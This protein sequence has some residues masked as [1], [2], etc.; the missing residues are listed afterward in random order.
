MKRGWNGG[1]WIKAALTTQ[2][3]KALLAAMLLVAS[4]VALQPLL[5][6]AQAAEPENLMQNVLTETLDDK[7]VT[8]TGELPPNAHLELAPV[9]DEAV[10]QVLEAADMPE[11]TSL[12]AVDVKIVEEDGTAWQPSQLDV[13]VK[14]ENLDVDNPAGVSVI[15]VLDDVDA[16]AQ[17][18]EEGASADSPADAPTEVQS[19]ELATAL[20]EAAD[21]AHE[22]TGANETIYLATLGD[23]EV[24][25]SSVAFEAD[26]FSVYIVAET[27]YLRTYRFFT[28]DEYGDYVEYAFYTDS[29][30]TTFTQT[31]KNGESPTVPQNPTNRQDSSLAFAGWYQGKV[32]GGSVV[33]EDEPYDFDNI[34]EIRATEAVDLYAR[35]GKFAYVIFHDQYDAATG[36]SPI[37]RTE[38]VELTEDEVTVDISDDRVIYSGDQDLIFVG[39]SETQISTP[40]SALDDRGNFVR[41]VGD[42][43][44]ISGTTHLYP[45][46]ETAYWLSFYSGPAG[47]GATYFSETYYAGGNGPASL[48]VPTRNDKSYIFKGWYASAT[49]NDETKEAE[50]TAEDVQI[51]DGEGRLIEGA[52]SPSIGISVENGHIKLTKNVTLF[53]VWE[54]KT[55]ANYLIVIEKQAASDDENLPDDKKH[56]EFAEVFV[57]TGTVGQTISVEGTDYLSLTDYEAYNRLHT[58]E[59]TAETNPYSTYVYNAT[60]SE[61]S[62][63]V[64]PDGGATIY[65]RYDW[66]TRPDLSGQTHWLNYVDSLTGDLAATDMPA[67]VQLAYGTPLKDYIPETLTCGI[68]GAY[69]FTGWYADN[70]CST[71]VFFEDNEEYQKYEGTKSLFVTMPDTDF[72][73]HAGWKEITYRVSID[74]N[75]GVLAGTDSTYFNA[76]YTNT[77]Q[78][79]STVTRDYVESASGTWYYV[80]HNRAYYEAHPGDDGTVGYRKTYYTQD[81]SEA[82][83]FTTFEYSPGVYRYAGWYEVLE[84]GSE[85]PYEFGQPVTHATEL[86]LHWT[87][88]GTYYISYDAGI[89]SLNTD[90]ELET[91]YIELDDSG[92]ADSAFIVVTRRAAA[93]EGYEFVG[94]QIRGDKSGALYYPGQEMTLLTKDTATV[95]GKKTIYLDAVYSQVAMAN[96]VYHA[97]GATL[98]ASLVD[99]GTLPADAQTSCNEAEG[100]Y[101]V[102]NLVNNSEITLSSGAGLTKENA[103][104]AGWC[105]SS[106]YDPDD[107]AHPLLDPSSDDTFNVDTSEPTDLYAV[108]KVQ[109]NFNLNDTTGNASFGTQGWGDGYTLNGQTYTTYAYLGSTVSWPP[110]DPVCGGDQ[111]FLG[112]SKQSEDG[113]P[114]DFSTPLAGPLTLY[115]QWGEKAHAPFVVLDSSDEVIVTMDGEG[116]WGNGIT[117]TV[118]EH[119]HQVVTGS[120][121]N[122]PYF[123]VSGTS[124]LAM[125]ANTL[126]SYDPT[127]AVSDNYVFAFATVATK[128]GVENSQIDAK[129]ILEAY[130]N[131]QD[132]KVH[133]LYEGGSDAALGDD[134]VICFIYYLKKQVQIHYVEMADAGDLTNV[135]T[136]G[137]APSTSP[138]LADESSA[139]DMGSPVAQPLEWSSNAYEYYSFAVGDGGYNAYNLSYIS[140]PSTSDDNLP[141]LKVQNSWRQF[142]Y[143]VDDGQTWYNCGYE[144]HLYVVYFTKQPTIVSFQAKTFGYRTDKLLTYVFDYQIYTVDYETGAILAT[145]W[146]TRVGDHKPLELQADSINSRILFTQAA[147]TEGRTTQR[148]DIQ[149]KDITSIDFSTMQTTSVKDQFTTTVNDA[150]TDEYSYTANIDDE[151]GQ[152]QNVT[153]VNTRKAQTVEIHVAQVEAH[154]GQDVINL[155]DTWRTGDS[156]VSVALGAGDVDFREALPA[157]SFVTNADEDYVFGAIIMGTDDGSI[158]IPAAAD[159]STNVAKIAFEED[160]PGSGTYDLYV[161]DADGNRV[162]ALGDNQIYYLYSPMMTIHYMLEGDNNELTPIVGADGDAIT[163]AGSAL[164][165]N[166]MTV[167]QCQKLAVPMTGLTISQTVNGSDFNMSPLLDNGSNQLDLVYDKIGLASQA[168]ANYQ[169][170]NVDQLMAVSEGKTVYFNID[171]SKLSW[172]FDG[173]TWTGDD[174]GGS[175]DDWAV[176]Y[177]IYRE[178]G[179]DLTV[180]KDMSPSAA[181][182]GYTEP[183]TVTLTSTAIN[184]TSYSVEGTGNSTIEAIYATDDHP[185]SITFTVTEGSEVKIIGLGAGRYTLAETDNQ[186]FTLSATIQET[187]SAEAQTLD[188]T[189]N[190][191]LESFELSSNKTVSLTNTAIPICRVNGTTFTTLTA[192][193]RWIKDYTPGAANTIEMIAD[194]LQP[195][196][197]APE[198]PNYLN[199]TL[200][201]ASGS[202]HTITRKDTFTTGA[203]FANA[204]TFKLQNVTLAGGG[205]AAAGPM[206]ANEGTLTIASGTTLTGAINIGNGGAVSSSAGSV[207]VSGGEISGNAA[208]NGGA[209]YVSGGTVSVS[210][211]SIANN[212]ASVTGGA[213]CYAG[214]DSVTVSG[215][216]I[217]GNGAQNGGALYMAAGTLDVS[218]GTAAG[219]AATADGGAAYLANATINVKGTAAAIGASGQPN[220]AQNG[221]GIYLNK[222][223]VSITAGSVSYNVAALSGG[224][225]YADQGTVSV[226]SS[227]GASNVSNNTATAL[228]GGGIFANTAS[229]S[230]TSS[231]GKT[232]SISGNTATSGGGIYSVSGTISLNGTTNTVNSVT[233]YRT[234]ISDN[235]ASTGNGGGVFAEKGEVT[236]K[237]TSLSGNRAESGNG[238]AVWIGSGATSVTDTFSITSNRAQNGSAIFSNSGQITFNSGTIGANVASAGGAVAV[239]DNSARLYLSG[240]IKI[241]GNTLGEGDDAPAANIYLD[242]D[243]DEIINASGNGLASDANVGVYVPGDEDSALVAK[244]G[245]PGSIFAMFTNSTNAA[246]FRNDRTNLDVSVDS[247]AKKLSWSKSF[248]VEIR[249]LASF[250]NSLEGNVAA[251]TTKGTVAHSATGGSSAVSEIANEVKTNN[252]KLLGNDAAVFAAA[253]V[254]S[255]TVAFKDYIT[256][257]YWST[258][259]SQWEY[260]GRDGSTGAFTRLIIYY[261]D[262]AYVSIENNTIE[263]GAERTLTISSLTVSGHTAINDPAGV[264]GFGYV[265]AKNDEIQDALYPITAEDLT[266]EPGETIKLLFAGGRNVP[267]SLTGSFDGGEGSVPYSLNGNTGTVSD[268]ANVSLSGTTLNNGNTYQII[269]GGNRSVCRIVTPEVTDALET[270]YAKKAAVAGSETNEYEY[271]FSSLNQ[272]KSFITTY[273]T[274]AAYP[275]GEATVEMLCDYLVPNGDSVTFP[276]NSKVT[277]TTAIGG[278]YCYAQAYTDEESLQPRASMSRDVNNQQSLIKAVCDTDS[279]ETTYLT[280]KGLDF[281]GKNIGKESN[282][283]IIN[284]YGTIVTVEH[285][286][287]KNCIAKNGGAMYIRARKFEPGNNNNPDNNPM[288]SCFVRHC[289]F[290]NC[291]SVAS[292]RKGGGAVWCNTLELTVEDCSFDSCVATDQGGALFHRIDTYKEGSKTTVTGCSFTDCNANA[293]GGFESDASV[294]VMDDCTFVR[295]VARAR[296]GGGAN[297][298]CND[299]ASSDKYCSVTITNCTFDDCQTNTSSDYYGG[300]I[301]SAAWE[302]T[303]EN[304]TINNCRTKK[305]GGIA[306]TSANAKWA[307]INNCTITDCSATN[308]G[309]GIYCVAIKLYIDCD[310]SDLSVVSDPEHQTTIRDCTATKGAGIYHYRDSANA[311]LTANNLTIDSCKATS[312]EGGGI[313]SSART[314]AF[315]D[316]SVSSCSATSNGGG[317]RLTEA[318]SLT[319]DALVITRCSSKGKGGGLYQNV[320]GTSASITGASE[321]SNNTASGNGGGLHLLMGASTVVGATIKDNYSAGSGGGIYHGSTANDKALTLDACEIVGNTAATAGGGVYT[322]ANLWLKND[323]SITANNL[324]STDDTN[325][326]GVYLQNGRRLTVG[327]TREVGEETDYDSTSVR[328]NYTTAGVASNLRLPM[329][330]SNTQNTSNVTVKCGLDGEIRVVNAAVR[331]TQFGVSDIAYPYGFSDLFAAFKADDDSLY[332]IL[333]RSDN[334][335]KQIVWAEDPVCKITDASGKLLYL[336]E[337]H[338]YPAVFDQLD[339]GDS[340]D[341]TYTTAFG[342]LRNATPQ[343]YTDSGTIYSGT[344]QVKMLVENYTLEKRIIGNTN[345]SRTVILTSAGVKDS[346]Y[347]FG[348]KTA[349]RCTITASENLGNE[350]MATVGF[351][352][353]LTN[354]AL[355]ANADMRQAGTKTRILAT[356]SGATGIKIILGRNATLVNAACTGNGGGVFLDGSGKTQSLLIEGGAI[357]NCSGANGGGIYQSGKGTVTIKGGNITQCSA[358]A[359]DVAGAGGGIYMANGS[360]TMSGG[361][362]TL[363]EAGQGGGLYIASGSS[364]LNMSGGSIYAN[365]V[366]E[367]GGGILVANGSSTLNFSGAPYVYDNVCGVGDEN[368]Y[369]CNVQMDKSFDGSKSNPHTIIHSKGLIR[370][371][372]IGVYVPGEEDTGSLY[373]SHGVETKPFATFEAGTSTDTLHYFI[374]DRN[375]LKGGCMTNQADADLKVYWIKIYSLELSC[376]VLSDNPEDAEKVFEFRVQLT[377][378][379]EGYGPAAELSARFGDMSFVDGEATVYL[380]SGETAIADLLPL[381]YSY[382]VTEVLDE[383]DRTYFTT[384]PA[385]YVA[386]GHMNIPT[387][388]VYSVAFYNLHAVCKITDANYGLLYYKEGGEYKPAV[389][390]ELRLAFNKLPYETFYSEQDGYY[391]PTTVNTATT[392]VEMLVENYSLTSGLTFNTTTRALLTTASTR[393]IDG[394]PY[395]GEGVATISR[396]YNGASMI[397]VN[398]D[399]TLGSITLDG[400]NDGTGTGYKGNS[401]GG[402][403]AVNSGASLTLGT[404]ATLRNSRIGSGNYGAGVSLA[405]GGKLYLSGAPVFDNNMTDLNLG[406]ASKN[407]GEAYTRP[408]QDIYIA[409]YKTEDAPS[410]VVTGDITADAGSIWVWAE[411]PRHYKHSSQ[412]A[413]LEDESFTGVAAFRNARKDSDTENPLATDPLYLTGVARGG[414]VLWTGTSELTVSKTITGR[415]ADTS[416][417]FEFTLA[418]LTEGKSYAWTRSTID[419]STWVGYAGVSTEASG[420]LTAGADGT[421]SFR[422]RNNEQITIELLASVNAVVSEE[423][424]LYEASYV[425]DGAEAVV[426]AETAAIPMGADRRLD[427]TNDFSTYAETGLATRTTPYA[428]LVLAGAVLAL[429]V[430]LGRSR[431]DETAV[432]RIEQPFTEV[433]EAKGAHFYKGSHFRE[434]GGAH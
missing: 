271:T 254:G 135:A 342:A 243:T 197:D 339:S 129:P 140:A 222:G 50:V 178:R 76:S 238:G 61:T 345:A 399:L 148:V 103:V 315:D 252:S 413:L 336:D 88:V 51:S 19:P 96:I 319:A 402:I 232:T 70:N 121:D 189:D 194:Y 233:V 318:T 397:T 67:S 104:F 108:W 179:Y 405:S 34:P 165:L 371:A 264:A 78:E 168:V 21:A 95:L 53:G 56:Y 270:D 172:S 196:S 203:M 332:G 31:I 260:K 385:G 14:I 71:R 314:V 174:Q 118:D 90:E 287:F 72:T 218:G 192:A 412:F 376:Q 191:Q 245:M 227:G 417:S 117:I 198:I 379:A 361:S 434:G 333:K 378:E 258:A 128:D 374:N 97:N 30:E 149:L 299:T 244:R 208:T 334:N 381:G 321:I 176:V 416:R 159:G 316:V 325:A 422:L 343:L 113:E 382:T 384:T 80:N 60:R 155:R 289:S 327:D 369:A 409:G 187:G 424:G 263:S 311:L 329:N 354:I 368:D 392:H 362:I 420:Y 356:N 269:F 122:A 125:D 400:G 266:L 26:S 322:L 126:S 110:F 123:L 87:K 36:T 77:I 387:Q 257:I 32:E 205:V 305:G 156:T 163:Y 326:A 152:T 157:S 272:A 429:C 328:E 228:Y 273:M 303:I 284:T 49:L 66:T 20:P 363:C 407:G 372:A 47:S 143:S 211:G 170:T 190:S 119:N 8:V 63:T 167:Q 421:V 278:T 133:V 185:G 23:S 127:W 25:G 4:M 297:F 265:F 105:E 7:R 153:F 10:A 59:V 285:C 242:K 207:T 351:N 240:S 406:N 317:M 57:R 5:R 33:L 115:A 182:T 350:T 347:P 389:F 217:T 83:E 294:V 209:I 94:W 186:N 352:L 200:T 106:V 418:G 324:T 107:E 239:G 219:N 279:V 344:Y 290:V 388:Y 286:D 310:P 275:G 390:S 161:K 147:G 38:R 154:V 313:N 28:L 39:W 249:Y 111:M 142:Q 403:F 255:G 17:G 304:C 259:N 430:Y 337:N 100:T 188:V 261:A 231:S 85:V 234:Q 64:R 401:N 348:S 86:K 68:S 131:S 250:A 404:G 6:R 221:A 367:A 338:T 357:R 144:P 37:S 277:M 16:I 425:L 212:E 224:G 162:A 331:G 99:Y 246:K 349:S 306:I 253:Y 377:G 281:D 101:S 335:H 274:T 408:H 102:S 27:T 1:Y 69:T 280:I 44:R 247:T 65:V 431:R 173:T 116:K 365:T 92:Y 419:G 301:R 3:L 323:T 193:V 164:S 171:N 282:G 309:G 134:E 241:T 251:G 423:N 98:D 341:K 139:F 340:N 82:T 291:E 312:G 302:T 428:G 42:S 391:T 370:G 375:G 268:V 276:E 210:G 177:V 29:G 120:W 395:V 394:F 45:I 12:F 237:K 386:T 181:E 166:G 214:T 184:R 146:D 226:A 383:A 2:G 432:E 35:F 9:D 73:V 346:L 109:V 320:G 355:N 330:G 293:A 236:I 141:S 136:A 24:N 411:Q 300:G 15:H 79:Y 22:A 75:Y 112:W 206:I 132:G 202:T 199:V 138:Y 43:I 145:E 62:C 267:W 18:L 359:D 46:F 223:T 151:L 137:D 213:I 52:V 307:I 41:N 360:I 235:V 160:E 380:K 288:R 298:Y 262:P 358:Y 48:E 124:H 130:Y 414:Y 11:A 426:S 292:D 54:Q 215:G 256:D 366:T 283:G 58:T 169:A 393:A 158:V 396:T 195:A 308:E 84:D 93:P 175:F 40:G 55:E 201:S 410:L 230:V 373:D 180:K 74:P 415:I 398:G 114:Y 364:D 220:T 183:F 229:V 248:Q 427:F 13:R 296:G 353:T 216:S 295:C 433:S 81:P 204:G 225:V 89:G 150:E 91:V